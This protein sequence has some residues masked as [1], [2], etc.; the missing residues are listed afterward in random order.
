MPAVDRPSGTNS[1]YAHSYGTV[2]NACSD[3]KE[4]FL[5]GGLSPPNKKYLLCVLCAFAV[6][7]LF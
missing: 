3:T 5:F 1:G 7:I 2:K 6:K 4:S